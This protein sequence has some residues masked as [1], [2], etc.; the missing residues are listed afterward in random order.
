MKETELGRYL[1]FILRHRPEAAGIALD[2]HGWADVKELIAGIAER[3]DRSFCRDTLEEIVRTDSKQRYAFNKD[4][5]AVFIGYPLSIDSHFN[6]FKTHLI[7][8]TSL[9]SLHL[10]GPVLRSLH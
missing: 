10:Q 9:T 7:T 2:E 5:T 6:D 8:A 4:R 1:C 3:K